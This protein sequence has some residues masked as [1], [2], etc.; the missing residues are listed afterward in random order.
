MQRVDVPA[1][2]AF[3]PVQEGEL[4]NM[5]KLIHHLP[6]PGRA[7]GAF[8]EQDRSFLRLRYQAEAANRSVG[9]DVITAD[10]RG[11]LAPPN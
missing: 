10:V 2:V 3:G 1:Y 9:D 8:E 4:R 7:A 5:G 11:H 6:M